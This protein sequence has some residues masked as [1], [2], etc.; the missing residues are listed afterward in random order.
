VKIV[1]LERVRRTSQYERARGRD[2][3]MQPGPQ[4]DSRAAPY[5][6]G[7]LSDLAGLGSSAGCE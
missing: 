3:L 5:G 2:Q 7:D 6:A 1:T 4:S